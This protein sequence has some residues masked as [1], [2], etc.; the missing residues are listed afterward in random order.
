MYL[1]VKVPVSIFKHLQVEKKL[2]MVHEFY[3]KF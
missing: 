1:S 2:S 3:T